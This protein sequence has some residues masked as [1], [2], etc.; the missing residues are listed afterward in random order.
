[1]KTMRD[2]LSDLREAVFTATFCRRNRHCRPEN[3]VHKFN[4]GNTCWLCRN[5]RLIVAYDSDGLG[6]HTGPITPVTP[7]GQTSRRDK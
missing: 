3:R 5:C 4:G 7:T 6:G 1:M 2:R